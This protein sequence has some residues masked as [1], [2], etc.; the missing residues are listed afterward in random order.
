MKHLITYTQNIED[1]DPTDEDQEIVV[2]TLEY[3][4][5]Y[6]PEMNN[7]YGVEAHVVS[8]KGFEGE[9]IVAEEGPY[10][11]SRSLQIAVANYVNSRVTDEQMGFSFSNIITEATDKFHS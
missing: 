7:E 4:I 6:T 5:E 2:G 10:S 11:P 1:T 9:P 8:V 3:L